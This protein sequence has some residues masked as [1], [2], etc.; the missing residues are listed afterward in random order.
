MANSAAPSCRLLL[1][2]FNGNLLDGTL[3]DIVLEVLDEVKGALTVVDGNCRSAF[4]RVTLGSVMADAG[5]LTADEFN[6]GS[7]LTAKSLKFEKF[8]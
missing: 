3:P 6:A 4:G 8:G 1:L 5:G 7:L 2:A